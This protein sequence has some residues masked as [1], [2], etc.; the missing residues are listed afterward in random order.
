MTA[1]FA[2]RCPCGHPAGKHWHVSP[3]ADVQCVRFTENEA[4]AVAHVLTHPALIT[5]F[6]A[7]YDRRRLLVEASELIREEHR[8]LLDSCCLKDQEGQPVRET[9]DEG[10]EPDV[11]RMEILLDRIIK[12]L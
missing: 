4:K 2:V 5:A 6:A 7:E 11:Q 3:H 8:S 12:A 10:A 9:L 1:A